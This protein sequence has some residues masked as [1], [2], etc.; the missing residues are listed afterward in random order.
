MD[1]TGAITGTGSDERIHL[2]VKVDKAGR[3]I[4][5]RGATLGAIRHLLSI[6]IRQAY[7]EL[8]IDVDIDDDRPREARPDRDS[9][10][11]GGRKRG[12]GRGRGRDRRGGG[13]EE[14]G[15]YPEEKLQALATRAAEKARETG[16]TITINLELNSY[17]RRI[18]HLT[19]AEI[20][21]VQSQ[22]EE[23]EAM[24]GDGNE[25]VTKF[26]QVLPE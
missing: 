21:G 24:D 10:D 1:V 5:K 18:V 3:I 11:R 23:R 6:A 26:V 22:S 25:V 19:V 17:D 2:S 15:R 9:D 16:Q 4:G 14:S 12:R 7:G 20:E 13:G 8:T